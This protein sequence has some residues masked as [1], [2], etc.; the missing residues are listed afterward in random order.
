[1]G[2]ISR[3]SS[4]TYKTSNPHPKKMAA[5]QIDWSKLGW[6]MTQSVQVG[7][8]SVSMFANGGARFGQFKSASDA[9]ASA[10]NGAKKRPTTIDF[11]S[12]K[13]ALPSQAKWIADMEAQYKAANVPKPVDTLSAAVEADDS[14]VAAAIEASQK[15]LDEAASGATAELATLKRLP[16]VRQMTYADVYRAF[17]ELNPYNP[18]EMEKHNW[19]PAWQT[20]E[21]ETAQDERWDAQR[22][23]VVAGNTDVNKDFL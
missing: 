21:E 19:E 1:M 7:S 12:Y 15:A 13:A 5:K 18:A 20:V 10:F 17:P 16:P 9:V 3:V 14:K 23:K 8:A 4:R 11:E 6:C 22:P 2:L